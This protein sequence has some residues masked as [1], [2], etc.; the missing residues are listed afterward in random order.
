MKDTTDK[1]K[2]QNIKD[3]RMPV[4]EFSYLKMIMFHTG[5]GGLEIANNLIPQCL[6]IYM[7]A[8][9]K[10]IFEEKPLFFSYKMD[11]KRN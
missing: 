9:S 2:M 10:L 7:Q 8:I 11:F 1:H 6:V 3:M 4:R 5:F